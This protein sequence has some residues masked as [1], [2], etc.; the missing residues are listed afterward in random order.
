MAE[1]KDFVDG[2]SGKMSSR[3]EELE[4]VAKEVG[5]VRRVGGTKELSEFRRVE[6]SK[7]EVIEVEFS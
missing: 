1:E 2:E 7:P 4:A 5:P 3:E 6:V